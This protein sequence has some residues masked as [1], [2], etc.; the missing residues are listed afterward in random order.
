M[1]DDRASADPPGATGDGESAEPPNADPLARLYRAQRTPRERRVLT[2]TAAAIG[3][4]LATVHW[5]GLFAGGA[6]VGLARPTLR[7][8]LTAGLGFGVVALLAAAARFALAGTLGDVLGTG[9]LVGVGIA[10]ALAGGILGG[11]VRG[12]FPDAGSQ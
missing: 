2:V 6:L 10:A 7:G 11:L 1:T 9:M 4:A 5:A 12:L 8:A 3:L